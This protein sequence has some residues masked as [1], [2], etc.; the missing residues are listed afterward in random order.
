MSIRVGDAVFIRSGIPATVKERNQT[1]GELRL[2][3]DTAKTQQD[4]RHGYLN[5]MEPEV[6]GKLYEILDQ[7]KSDSE[8]PAQRAED[9]RRRILDLEQ[10]P[11]NLPLTKYM[12]AEMVH[13][14][15]TYS[16]KPTEYSIHESKAR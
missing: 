14:M 1:T 6:R 5:G 12:R 11:R 15:N 3:S 10:D 2:E 13:I 16:I 7:V 9:L 8:E 4:V